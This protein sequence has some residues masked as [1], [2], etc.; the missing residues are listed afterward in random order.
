MND[1]LS[2]F[3]YRETVQ[4]SGVGDEKVIRQRGGVGVYAHVQVAVHALSRGQG[5]ELAWNAGLNIPHRFAAAV[6]RGLQ[7]AL[8]SGVLAGLELTDVYA[9][10]ENGSYH[11]EDS[12]AD[13]F[14]EAAAKAT[15]KALRGARP[16]ILEALASVSITVPK[17]FIEVVET[18][19]ASHHG[20]ATTMR[21]EAPLQSVTT[22]L[23]AVHLIELMA[24]LLRITEGHARI[25]TAT[26]G[27][28]P[29]PEPP[30]TIEEWVA[31]R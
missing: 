23:P 11:E 10:V 5:M 16:L 8:N 30:D 26:A 18:T 1:G 28:R 2:R 22:D 15:T 19:V 17:E 12:T 29:R 21:S 9:S 25:S 27:F 20:Q 7:D 4:D 31:H 3:F 6:V 24:E 14:R 13:A